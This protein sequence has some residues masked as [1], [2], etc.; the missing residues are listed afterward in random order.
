MYR[1]LRIIVLL[2]LV[3]G[4]GFWLLTRPTTEPESN[5]AG[6]E[7]DAARGEVIFYAGGCASCHAREG[8]SGEEKLVLA[9]GMGFPSAF[10]TFYAP[11]ISSD[12]EAGIGTWSA[13]DLVNA[14]K[15]GTSPEGQHYYPAFPYTSYARADLQDIVDLHAFLQ[16]LPA[17]AT[18]S[19]PHDVGFPFNIRRSLG[20]W[21]LLFLKDGWVIEDVEGPQLE[22]G[23]YLVEALGHCGE[24]HTPRNA[25]GGLK[26]GEWLAGAVNPDGKGR[27]PGITPATLD[28]S[29]GDVA[30]YLSSGFTPD[31]DSVGGH[32]AAV[33][34]NTAQLSQEDRD[35]IA[36]YVK[37]VPEV[38]KE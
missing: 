22:R 16:T 10:G 15:H 28:W 33:V 3:G 6:L 25:L 9:G 30:E 23:R 24:C 36:A 4:L 19:K 8:A 27:T 32:M 21:K 29:A 18:P 26:T 35:A 37:A 38:A 31:F 13:L 14:M 12:P 20:G 11:N 34:E 2:A 1:F 7:G 5:L 17:D